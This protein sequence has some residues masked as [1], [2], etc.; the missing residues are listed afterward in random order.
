MRCL[1]CVLAGTMYV[2]K[3]SCRSRD[4]LALSLH[5][6]L[7]TNGCYVRLAQYTGRRQNSAETCYAC[8]VTSSSSS[9]KIFKLV[10]V[11][12]FASPLC[13]CSQHAPQ[14]QTFSLGRSPVA[15]GQKER[16]GSSPSR[17]VSELLLT[18]GPPFRSC[19]FSFIQQQCMSW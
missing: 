19:F 11:Q 5:V 2:N 3:M 12:I 15:K 18:H 14:K 13:L 4:A 8:T 1:S 16:W 6:T 7:I 10:Q 9:L 17:S